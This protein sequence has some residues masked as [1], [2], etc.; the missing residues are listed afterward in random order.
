M[1]IEKIAKFYRQQTTNY[2]SNP[3]I[4]IDILHVKKRFVLAVVVF[5]ILSTQLES[6]S[7]SESIHAL[8]KCKKTIRISTA[9]LNAVTQQTQKLFSLSK[10]PNRP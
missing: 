7:P 2:I 6:T 4:V 5:Y 8:H 10:L 1:Q 9:L 3:V